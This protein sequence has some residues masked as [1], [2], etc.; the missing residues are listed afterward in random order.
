MP[1]ILNCK[2]WNIF[3][4]YLNN[5]HIW[6]EV[7]LSFSKFSTQKDLL[8]WYISNSTYPICNSS[9][10]VPLLVFSILINR[11]TNHF[12]AETMTLCY[13]WL[14]ILHYTNTQPTLL[15]HWEVYK[16]FHFYLINT[17]LIHLLC[18]H[19][20]HSGP[21][22]YRCTFHYILSYIL[23]FESYVLLNWKLAKDF[24]KKS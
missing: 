13:P 3:Y 15:L 6:V 5:S 7:S 4:Q 18:L 16:F 14:F 10:P 11:P 9:K 22:Y 24:K 17:F 19:C 23:K 2:D 20:Y 21:S 8:P 1:L 12:R